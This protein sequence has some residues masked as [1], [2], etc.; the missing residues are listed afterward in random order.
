MKVKNQ[1]NMPLTLTSKNSYNTSEYPTKLKIKQKRPSSGLTGRN[2]RP[3]SAADTIGTFSVDRKI[4]RNGS[5][6]EKTI[7]Q[8]SI[9]NV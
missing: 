3:S 2:M 7:Q 1:R 6:L 5:N 8:N 9:F 4:V